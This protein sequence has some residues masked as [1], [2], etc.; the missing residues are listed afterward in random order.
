MPGTR[1]VRDLARTL[2]RHVRDSH[3]V[4]GRAPRYGV[5]S[6]ITPSLRV[7]VTGTTLTLDE[8]DDDVSMS[9]HVR[10][11]DKTYGLVVG[12]TLVLH[13][14]DDGDWVATDVVSQ[15]DV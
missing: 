7:Q 12:D 15:T 5:V 3:E 14:M 2:R 1:P 11:Y 6:A 4:H 8:S 13:P 9:Q 10:W